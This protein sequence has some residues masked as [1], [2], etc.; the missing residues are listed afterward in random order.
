M[1]VGEF[2][3][4]YTMIVWLQKAADYRAHFAAFFMPIASHYMIGEKKKMKKKHVMKA[5]AVLLLSGMM[6]G[7]SGV[8]LERDASIMIVGNHSAKL[9]KVSYWD[10]LNDMP[11]HW[12]SGWATFDGDPK[13]DREIGFLDPLGY[14][15]EVH[16]NVPLS[17]ETSS[18]NLYL[19]KYGK[20]ETYAIKR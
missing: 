13:A 12:Q 4:G 10:Y 17:W 6:M 11:I 20:Y 14:L 3:G 5:G 9:K 19:N 1:R 18:V 7:C 15:R 2:P 16:I 8:C